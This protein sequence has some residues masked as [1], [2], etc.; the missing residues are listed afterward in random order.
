MPKLWH[1]QIQRFIKYVL[2]GG[3]AAIVDFTV[4]VL[5]LRFSQSVLWLSLTPSPTSAIFY[6][7]SLGILCGFAWSFFWQR[8]WVFSAKGSATS[9]LLLTIA[10]LMFN[11]IISSLTIPLLTNNWGIPVEWSKITLQITVVFWNFFI[12]QHL[13]FRTTKQT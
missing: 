1:L 11:I 8:Y 10:L 9:Q 2:V 6:A 13:I 5:V 3:G 12:Y 7:N 4:F